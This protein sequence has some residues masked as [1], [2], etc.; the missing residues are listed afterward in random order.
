VGE[1]ANLTSHQTVHSSNSI[2]LHST[3]IHAQLII[4]Y[5]E[6]IDQRS[7]PSLDFGLGV[8]WG[9]LLHDP[10]ELRGR[11]GE[12]YPSPLLRWKKKLSK[13]CSASIRYLLACS[14]ISHML[15]HAQ[16]SLKCYPTSFPRSSHFHLLSLQGKRRRG[17][18]KRGWLLPRGILKCYYDENHIF[19]IGAILRH[20]Q[21]AYMRRKMLF[22]ISKY[23]FLFQ[24][25]SSF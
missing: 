6:N 16:S 11:V 23:L 25:F 9:G 24:R 13:E 20:K 15:L 22:T 3:A 8:G 18:W 12:L 10:R 5:G 7:K 14:V 2:L 4:R 19:S 21:V 1:G 17:P